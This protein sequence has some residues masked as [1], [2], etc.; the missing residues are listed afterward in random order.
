M[1]HYE[2]ECSFK[3]EIPKNFSF[4]FDKKMV[5]YVY[6]TE[7]CVKRKMYLDNCILYDSKNTLYSGYECV[8]FNSFILSLNNKVSVEKSEE[9]FTLENP[10]IV[11]REYTIDEYGIRWAQEGNFLHVEYEFKNEE[12]QSTEKFINVLSLSSKTVEIFN[13]LNSFKPF[14][15]KKFLIQ[16]ENV[17]VSRKFVLN[18]NE[19]FTKYTHKLDGIRR[20]GYILGDELIIPEIALVQ[21]LEKFLNNLQIIICAFEEI[22]D[23]CGNIVHVCIDACQVFSLSG[24]VYTSIDPLFAFQVLSRFETRS[25]IINKVFDVKPETESTFPTD[26][27]LGFSKNEIQKFKTVDTIDLLYLP[28]RR[29]GKKSSGDGLFFRDGPVDELCPDFSFEIPQVESNPL[30][31]FFIIEYNIIKSEKKCIVNRLRTDKC[32]ANKAKDFFSVI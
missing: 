25:F 27:Y 4:N 31:S 22:H 3:I 6:K 9:P 2:F 5:K 24:K 29:R 32:T 23:G 12:E 18:E 21:K 17:D 7:T 20:I 28:K 13:L 26:G 19:N 8:L 30:Q 10:I 1:D 16:L 14:C 15:S 11:E